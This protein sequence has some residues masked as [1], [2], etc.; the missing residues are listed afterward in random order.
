[1]KMM[2]VFGTRPEVIKLAPVI[3]EAQ[4][5]ADE[6]ELLVC[7]TGQHREMLDQAMAVFNIQADVDLEL[8]RENQT[9]ASLTARL[10]E[11][12][13]AVLIE[14]RPDVVVVQ[15]D[16]TSSF[17]GGLA[18]FY[19]QIPVAHVEAGLRTGDLNSP[20][21]EELN[22]V[23]IARMARWHFPPTQLAAQHLLDEQVDSGKVVI[24]GN[25]VVDAINLIRGRWENGEDE[26]LPRY[27][28]NK[29]QVL[30]TTHRR[31]NQGEGLLNI[32]AAIKTLTKNHP[33]LGFVFPVHLNPKV[34]DIVHKELAGIS[35]L[36][37]IAPLDFKANL[38]LQS[39]C[40]LIVTDSGGIQEE[41]PSFAVPAV[42]MRE[43]TERSEG[44][45]AGFAILA[46]TETAAIVDAAE[47]FL[48]DTAITNKLSSLENPYGD[49]N[50][51]QRILD[52]L[53][54]MKVGV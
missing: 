9:L 28:L 49:G 8:M 24:T 12:L 21:P 19:Q 42:V 14:H 39:Q 6:V 34:K 50:A 52:T 36:K 30:V 13:T 48:T 17:V 3:L 18:A 53:L 4:S 32:C 1:M 45:D 51:S 7:S 29:E 26:I 16:T 22:R 41:A 35:N 23:L 37:M 20:F 27:F 46:G 10:M 47:H 33:E 5:R 25:T 11:S 15:G 54:G 2:V 38:Q 31:E 43:H 40:K 44:I